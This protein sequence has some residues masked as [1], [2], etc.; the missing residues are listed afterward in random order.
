MSYTK[1]NFK[2]G[3]KLLA[4]QLNEMDDQIAR[5]EAAIGT[6]GSGVSLVYDAERRG[7]SVS[8]VQFEGRVRFV[9]DKL[10]TNAKAVLDAAVPERGALAGLRLL[11][12]GGKARGSYVHNQAVAV[13]ASASDSESLCG[14][15]L[16]WRNDGSYQA[17]PPNVSYDALLEAGDTLDA[18]D[19][20]DASWS[21]AAAPGETVVTAAAA[22]TA[23]DCKS[24]IL[25][26]SFDGSGKVVLARLC[27][28]TAFPDKQA[29]MLLFTGGTAFS[30]W[31]NG[32]VVRRRESGCEVCDPSSFYDAVIEAGDQFIVKEM[33][34]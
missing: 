6:T 11:V 34:V 25:G 1:H 27:G 10:L 3:T 30:E 19:F 15:V 21:E 7:L 32:F 18:K 4:A 31:K 28:K 33:E 24:A 22:T 5:N 8:G 20:D 2:K 14:K 13:I 17:A 12:L 23:P 26:S 16:R 9:A 29:V